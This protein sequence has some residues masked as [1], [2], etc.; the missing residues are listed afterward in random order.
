MVAVLWAHGWIASYWPGGAWEGADGEAAPP[1][2]DV[3]FVQE[4][5]PT[6]PPVFVAAPVPAR[7]TPRP[8]AKAAST[9]ERA[10][11]EPPGT[12]RVPWR[13]VA[14]FVIGRSLHLRVPGQRVGDEV[15][16]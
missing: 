5:V 13:P 1:P 8:V 10:A 3:A 4:L 15:L 11:S 7:R 16:Q 2:I 9:P 12:R 6:A 14:G